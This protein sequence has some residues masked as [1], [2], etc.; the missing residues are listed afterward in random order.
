MKKM[1]TALLLI[2]VLVVAGCSSNDGGAGSTEK[3]TLKNI[4]DNKK[5]VVGIAPGYFPFE[6]K[7]IE[8]G[9]VGYDI[10]LANAVGEALDTEVEFKQFAFD[11][12]GPALQIGE[13]DMVIAGMTIRGD[14]ALSISMS[15]PYYK[16]G[17]AIMVPAASKGI[18]SWEELDVKGNKIAVGIGTTGALLAKSQFKNAEVVDYEDFPLAATTMGSGQA[19]AVVYDEPAIAV[20]RLEHEGEVHQL[21]GLLSAEN[22]GIAVKKN[23]FE[24]IQ[25]LNSFLHSYVDSPEELE[26]RSRWFEESDWLDKV[27]GE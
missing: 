22:L 9:F 24:T 16:T 12:L 2:L 17:Q 13:V 3:S 21:E 14:R 25:W 27:S 10:D 20:W 18:K 1:F 8:G 15:N 5:L 11:G 19:D 26:S 23:D 4:K 6:M 7:S